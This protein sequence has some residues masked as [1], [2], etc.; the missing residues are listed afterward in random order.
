[1]G[2]WLSESEGAKFW[3]SCRTDLKNRGVHDIS[4][5]CVGGLSGFAEAIHTAFPR[6]TV[7]RR[8]V[9]LARAALKYSTD[10]DSRE[11]AADLKTIYQSAMVLK[12]ESALDA[13]EEK[14]VQKH[15]TIVQQWRGQGSNIIPLFELPAPI[16]KA[17]Y[18]A[19][20]IESVKG[21]NREFARNRK[22]YPNAESALKMI[23]LAI[24]EGSKTWTMPTTGW[25]AALNHFAIVFEGH[26]PTR[27]A[28]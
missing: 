6:T 26:L 21:V 1:L 12:A 13:F 17:T 19:N 20:A 22:Q 4:L 14:W 5:V 7:Q 23:Y 10:K 24:H 25:K 16:R 11:V 9:H 27:T 15:P 3:L 28:T 8:I 2:W 18:P